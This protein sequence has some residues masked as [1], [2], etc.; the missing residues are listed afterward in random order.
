MNQP[1]LKTVNFRGKNYTLVEG[2]IAFFNTSHPR[3]GIKTEIIGNPAEWVFVKAVVTPDVDKPERFFTGH[4]QSKWEGNINRQS[5]LENAETSAIGRALASMGLGGGASY[6]EMVKCGATEE[7]AE[8]PVSDK[9]IR[10]ERSAESLKASE[11]AEILEKWMVANP[12]YR[13]QQ[14]LDFLFFKGYK[15]DEADVMGDP[16]RLPEE[17]LKE[18]AAKVG[19]LAQAINRWS[20]T[21]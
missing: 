16:L 18:V 2:R 15:F 14:I 17:V 19:R 21:K 8:P 13:P 20:Q 1:Q 7:Q 6:D 5:A 12:T 11:A 9:I 10:L 4:S 3:G